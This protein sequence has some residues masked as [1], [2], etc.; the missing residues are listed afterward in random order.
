MKVA[1]CGA[2]GMLAT[3]VIEVFR[4]KGHEVIGLSIDDMDI[5]RIQAV[6]EKLQA[7][8]PDIIFNAAA[9][10]NVDGCESEPDL[11][12][13]VN[14]I[15]PRNLAIAAEGLDAALIHISTDYIFGGAGN[16][17][18]REYD[19][20]NPRSVYGKSK[21]DGEIMVRSHCSRHYIVRTAWLFGMHGNNFVRTMLRLAGER[22]LLSV[23][24]DQL[25]SPT[26]TRDL[27]QATALLIEKPAYGTYH[28]TNGD[29]CTW[30]E[31][32]RE[33]LRQA[34]LEH[35]KVEPTTTEQLK[36]PADRPRY[37]VLDN[38]MWRL[39]GYA[40]LRPYYEA[41]Q[42]YLQLEKNP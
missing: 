33:I 9:F 42:E 32:T 31:F 17:P 2:G 10:T 11:A 20:V 26:Y 38:Y 21:L 19:Q 1:V 41:L 39:E 37:S 8:R 36:R 25:G 34:G 22:E 27:A 14:A 29:A 5:T 18:Y 13:K 28:I 35:V 7:V 6:L 15:G 30:F 3:D 40:P 4:Q 12:Y 23:V 16:K 24:N